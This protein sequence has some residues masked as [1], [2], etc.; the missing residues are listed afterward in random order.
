MSLKNK[1]M[2]KG[3]AVATTIW[4]GLIIGVLLLGF[5]V[6]NNVGAITEY[7]KALLGVEYR[8]EFTEA[9]KCSYYRCKDGC[10]VAENSVDSDLLDCSDFC[11]ALP[12]EFRPDNK[13][14]GENAKRFP[15]EVT[16]EDSV[17]ITD[18]WWDVVTG[19]SHNTLFKTDCTVGRGYRYSD[20]NLIFPEDSEC[21]I[22]T[23][24]REGVEYDSCTISA[25]GLFYLW[26]E[27]HYWPDAC[28]AGV[29]CIATM[30]CDHTPC[31]ITLEK[32]VEK[33]I[34][35]PAI[36]DIGTADRGICIEDSDYKVKFTYKNWDAT[37]RSVAVLIN[38]KDETRISYKYK[39]PISHIWYLEGGY[40]LKV[41]FI[42]ME[43]LP[44]GGTFIF[45]M[46]Y[47]YVGDRLWCDEAIASCCCGICPACWDCHSCTVGGSC[48]D[49]GE[50]FP[51]CSVCCGWG[52]VCGNPTATANCY[53]DPVKCPVV[54]SC[55]DVGGTCDRPSDCTDGYECYEYPL[56]CTEY[57]ATCCCVL[58]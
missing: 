44:L 19:N 13:V 40:A 7:I 39:P 9:I 38:D 34:K 42:G 36:M 28:S 50:P 24:G 8:D 32:N 4:L 33:E 53:P 20:D 41:A 2:R 6:F 54:L 12:A 47:T 35:L 46:K 57:P 18:A 26:S 56:D 27:D 5:Y 10:A 1:K 37:S 3:V 52:C 22:K 23:V 45:S 11:S 29:T 31:D 55:A 15:I 17:T 21:S 25:N 58:Q 49:T 51:T 43:G 48:I 16:L 30:I 14:C